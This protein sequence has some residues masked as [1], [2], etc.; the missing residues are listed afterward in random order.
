M[1]AMR[2]GRA[3]RSPS[4]APWAQLC[5]PAATVRPGQV[6]AVFPGVSTILRDLSRR[7]ATAG[8][9]LALPVPGRGPDPFAPAP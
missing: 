6:R 4:L 5:E 2:I 8:V 3:F 1:T 9:T 7:A